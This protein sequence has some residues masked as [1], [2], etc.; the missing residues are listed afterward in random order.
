MNSDTRITPIR[1]VFTWHLGGH[2]VVGLSRRGERDTVSSDNEYKV[3]IS[4]AT[5]T[6]RY[7]NDV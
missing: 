3:K 1:G 5:E 7:S 6:D 2:G 4:E